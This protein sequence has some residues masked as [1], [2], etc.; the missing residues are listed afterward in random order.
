MPND[1]APPT[2]RF[3]PSPTGNVHIGNIRT[4]ILNWLFAR[5]HGGTVILRFD[6]TDR[7]RARSEFAD[8]IVEDLTWLGLDF[9][10]LERQ[11]DRTALFSDAADR[12]RKAGRLYPCFETAEDVDRKR[13][14]QRARGLPPIYDRAALKLT[15]DEIA[16]REAEGRKPHWRFLLDN[17]GDT[18][19][20]T[21][22]PTPVVWDDLIR[23][24]QTVD[25]GSLS[26]P[27]MIREDGSYLYTFTSVVDDADMGITHI[28]RGEDHVTN[29]AVQLQ[30]FEAL[31]SKAPEFAHHS[32]MVGADG[33]ALSKRLGD[34]SI[35]QFREDGLEPE[36][37]ASLAAL[38]GT[39]DPIE[40]HA[41]TVSLAQLFAF[42]K[43]SRSPARFD[44]ND[45]VALN[46]KLLQNAN[47]DRVAEQLKAHGVDGGEAFWRAIRGNVE[48][49][50]DSARWWQVVSEPLTP[51]IEDE[52]VTGAA[53][54]LMPDGELGPDNWSAWMDAIKAETGKKGRALFMPIRLALTGEKS[55][56][57]LAPLGPII[58][59]ERILARLKGDR[60]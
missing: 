50:S 44:V 14:L 41:D 11:S 60:A 28:V 39:S 53:A 59:R 48:R 4:A 20:G 37:V 1:V 55:G 31:G 52:V 25:A 9:D 36:A 8:N 54:Q 23:G 6:D 43:I 16:A 49:I 51:V 15:A 42:S 18:L 38:I 19:G 40:P 24:H 35:R 58:G 3:A 13:K 33:A 34:L 10:R 32:L 46:A 47:F 30:L 2:V 27:V 26:D 21:P 17:A 7:E 5:A 22:Q 29:T 56:P 12:L 57:E 45:I